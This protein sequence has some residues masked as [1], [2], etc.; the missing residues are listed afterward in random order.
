MRKIAWLNTFPR[1]RFIPRM[2]AS[3]RHH[4]H[5]NLAY[6][7]EDAA[8]GL[9]AGFFRL[10]ILTYA[11]TFAIALW[12]FEAEIWL[13]IWMM[14]GFYYLPARWLYKKNIIGQ[15]VAGLTPGPR[16]PA[17]DPH[18]APRQPV[19]LGTFDSGDDQWDTGTMR[20][21]S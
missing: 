20:R 5:H 17:Y 11:W 13:V 6:A 9:I 16:R 2:R 7:A 18:G 19:D 15:T 1:L 3:R 12:A 14:Y 10:M 21:R 8:G 4:H